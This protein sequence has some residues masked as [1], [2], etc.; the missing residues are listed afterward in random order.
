MTS[1]KQRKAL[2][3]WEDDARRWAHETARDLVMAMVT[4]QPTAATAYRIGVVLEPGERVWA[5]CPVRFL[6]ERH[7]GPQ[8]GPDW[9]PPI[10]R[11]LA[12]SDRILGRLA[13]DRLYGW[14]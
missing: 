1:R 2:A 13:D 5:E 9:L 8:P 6:Q 7:V 10:R 4:G 12:T 11:W 14:R 3:K